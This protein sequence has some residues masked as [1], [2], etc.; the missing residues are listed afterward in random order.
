MNGY[1]WPVLGDDGGFLH[2]YE[3]LTVL[4]VVSGVIVV[5][6]W[7][8]LGVDRGFGLRIAVGIGRMLSQFSVADRLHT[9]YIKL[10]TTYP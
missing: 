9:V 7:L 2:A 4:A 1:S 3:S 6:L 8:L 5:L 10:V